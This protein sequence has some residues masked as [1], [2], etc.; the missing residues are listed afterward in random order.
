MW[1]A[2]FIVS[3]LGLVLTVL[4]CAGGVGSPSTSGGVQGTATPIAFAQ[5][6]VD[7]GSVPTAVVVE[8]SGTASPAGIQ[9][10]DGCITGQAAGVPG[11]GQVFGSGVNIVVDVDSIQTFSRAVADTSSVVCRG[12]TGQ[13]DVQ[14]LVARLN[15]VPGMRVV[16]YTWPGR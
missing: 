9:F 16:D 11:R 1:Q 12:G 14:Q 10:E 6:P 8:Q 2:G 7:R 15:G 13:N 3:M 5:Q 4:A